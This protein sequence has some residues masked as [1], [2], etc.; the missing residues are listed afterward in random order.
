MH[1]INLHQ[2]Q[3][4]GTLNQSHKSLDMLQHLLLIG[5]VIVKTS[6]NRLSHG[7]AE[8]LL[9]VYPSTSENLI[10][11]YSANEVTVNFS[12]SFDNSGNLI[13]QTESREYLDGRNEK[14]ITNYKYKAVGE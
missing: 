7:V 8:D 9:S 3:I 10:F 2:G 6:V 4:I 1:R 14:V 12:Y 11:G 13:S 5:V